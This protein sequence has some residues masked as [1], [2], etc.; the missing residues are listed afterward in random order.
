M[1]GNDYMSSKGLADSLFNTYYTS[2][3]HPL[4]QHFAYP[5]M[6]KAIEQSSLTDIYRLYN[7]KGKS[8]S[9]YS[10]L[11]SSLIDLMKP[12][13]EQIESFFDAMQ[14]QNTIPQ[15][16]SELLLYEL[17]VYMLSSD[18]DDLLDKAPKLICESFIDNIKIPS[19]YTQ[20]LLDKYVDKYPDSF[21]TK[22]VKSLRQNPH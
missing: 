9:Y 22:L 3:E 14:A 16:F 2:P 21:F 5:L 17:M 20:N 11:Y 18:K 4:L 12:S 6:K 19:M 13:R 15:K 8:L 7:I 1:S 10:S